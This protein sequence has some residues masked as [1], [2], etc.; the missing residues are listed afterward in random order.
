MSFIPN[1]ALHHI[2][3]HCQ[4]L[5]ASIS[6]PSRGKPYEFPLL[7][8]HKLRSALFADFALSQQSAYGLHFAA[9]VEFLTPQQIF[10]AAVSF[11]SPK[12]A[13]STRILITYKFRTMKIR[14]CC[15]KDL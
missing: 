12:L 9:R 4:A 7:E 14:S 5:N 8:S 13:D 6:W 15:F 2:E 10:D 1:L 3:P 11:R